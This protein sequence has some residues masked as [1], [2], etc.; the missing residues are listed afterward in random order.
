MRNISKIEALRSLPNGSIYD[1][2]G[3][4]AT[5]RLQHNITMLSISTVLLVPRGPFGSNFKIQPG[6]VDLWG[7]ETAS[8]GAISYNKIRKDLWVGT[9]TQT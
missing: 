3:L 2:E 1:H 6:I 9:V 7:V 8:P 4:F 5:P